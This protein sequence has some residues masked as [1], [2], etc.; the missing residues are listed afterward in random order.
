M[1]H[2]DIREANI[3]VKRQKTSHDHVSATLIDFGIAVPVGDVPYGG[4]WTPAD[5]RK[6]EGWIAPELM[7][8]TGEA[9][10]ASEVYSLGMLAHR[11]EPKNRLYPKRFAAWVKQARS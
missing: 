9:S 7:S 5:K 6:F 10:E 2:N 3:C 4:N 1:T 8:R 11:L